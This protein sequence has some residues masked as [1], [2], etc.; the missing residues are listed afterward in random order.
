VSHLLDTNTFVNYLRLGT[1]SKA[2]PRILAAP[3]GSVY[4]CSIVL[5]ELVYG[6]FHSAPAQVGANLALVTGLRTQFVSLPFNDAAADKAGEIRAH[7][8]AKGLL[9]GP[10]DLLIAG[11]ALAN[12]LTV[13]THNTKEFNRVPGLVIDDWL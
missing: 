3:P 9:I 2:T 4:L 10:H 11:I 12:G 5:A 7:L 1:A 8:A 13:V 6:A